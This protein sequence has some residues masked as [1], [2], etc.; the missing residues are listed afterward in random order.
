MSAALWNPIKANGLFGPAFWPWLIWVRIGRIGILV[1]H[2]HMN[3]P[4]Y[5]I[6]Q[7]TVH[8]VRNPLTCRWRWPL[9][10]TLRRRCLASRWTG[11][12]CS[13]TRRR[14]S[15]Y[16]AYSSSWRWRLGWTP[17]RPRWRDSLGIRKR[18]VRSITIWLGKL[19]RA[20][21]NSNDFVKSLSLEGLHLPFINAVNF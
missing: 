21:Q 10:W 18:K 14:A 19:C 5:I 2:M 15:R 20:E 16:P 11:T 7:P 12:T 17:W 4:T 8:V 6:A 3:G 1:M 9:G 13:R